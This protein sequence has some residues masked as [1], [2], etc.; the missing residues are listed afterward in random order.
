MIGQVTMQTNSSYPFGD[1]EY[2]KNLWI[3]SLEKHISIST[4]NLHGIWGP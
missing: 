3:F 1:H 4:H 2:E